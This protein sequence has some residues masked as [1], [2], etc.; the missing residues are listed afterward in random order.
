MCVVVEL[1]ESQRM[2]ETCQQREAEETTSAAGRLC[3]YELELYGDR[4]QLAGQRTATSRQQV[5]KP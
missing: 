3:L 5:V 4:Q 2:R 1:G